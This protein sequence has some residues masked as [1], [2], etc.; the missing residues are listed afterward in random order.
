MLTL[1][2]IVIHKSMSYLQVS[3]QWYKACNNNEL[4]KLKSKEIK[5][6]K[7]LNKKPRAGFTELFLLN[8]MNFNIK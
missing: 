3:K 7:L 6:G 5:L 8:N 2:I 1:E 4:W